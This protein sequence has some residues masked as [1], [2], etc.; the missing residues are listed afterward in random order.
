MTRVEWKNRWR[1]GRA[2]EEK[3]KQAQKTNPRFRCRIRK[4]RANLDYYPGHAPSSLMMARN[5]SSLLPNIK[6]LVEVIARTTAIRTTTN[7]LRQLPCSP[8][9]T[10]VFGALRIETAPPIVNC[11]SSPWTRSRETG[12]K[13]FR[14]LPLISRHLQ[15]HPGQYRRLLS[16][17]EVKQP[18]D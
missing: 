3:V 1:V 15:I 5:P 18:M 8:S 2:L 16:R 9:E 7:Q 14:C 10:G 4:G 13:R 11:N 6:M 12:R 17:L